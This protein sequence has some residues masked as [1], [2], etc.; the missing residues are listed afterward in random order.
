MMPMPT[1]IVR[2]PEIWIAAETDNRIQGAPF[3]MTGPAAQVQINYEAVEITVTISPL[4]FLEFRARLP[5]ESP[6]GVDLLKHYSLEEYMAA[7]AIWQVEHT[8]WGMPLVSEMMLEPNQVMFVAANVKEWHATFRRARTLLQ[9][10]PQPPIQA[11]TER[12]MDDADPN[13][14][15]PGSRGQADADVPVSANDA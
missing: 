6:L 9:M 14:P 15:G 3:R 4:A 10:F 8:A 1:Q 11:W 13:S 2:W 5:L 12:M 7:L